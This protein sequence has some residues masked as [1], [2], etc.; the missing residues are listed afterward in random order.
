MKTDFGPG[1]SQSL[2]S[3]ELRVDPPPPSGGPERGASKR[4]SRR[5]WP[6]TR[7]RGPGKG[8]GGGRGP[9]RR[10]KQSGR[11]RSGKIA[12]TRTC[13][14]PQPKSP[15]SGATAGRSSSEERRAI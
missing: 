2:T 8:G 6:E 10:R 5:A 1:Q 3:Q 14:P 4:G 13:D 7:A 11:V 9:S 15:H 12:L